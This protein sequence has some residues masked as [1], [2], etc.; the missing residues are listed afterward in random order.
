M[1]SITKDGPDI[2][3][4][5]N[6]ANDD[7]KLKEKAAELCGE[8]LVADPERVG[9][10]LEPVDLFVRAIFIRKKCSY[11]AVYVYGNPT[12]I[13]LTGPSEEEGYDMVLVRNDETSR[14]FGN[15]LVRFFRSITY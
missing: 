14:L 3:L 15:P 12:R 9:I 1:D 2:V 10:D 7:Q 11:G 8:T 6:I 5:D 13:V 4:V